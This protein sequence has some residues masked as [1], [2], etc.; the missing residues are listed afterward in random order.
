MA[1]ATTAAQV[2]TLLEAVDVS[3]SATL[4]LLDSDDQF[5]LDISEDLK[6]G[7]IRRSNYADIHGTCDLRIARQLQWGSARLQL[8]LTVTSDLVAL[9][10][11]WSMG[12]YLPGIP[13]RPVGRTPEVWSVKGSDKL[14]LLRSP[15]GRAVSA[16]EGDGYIATV[17][18]LIAEAGE[19]KVRI[20][21]ASVAKVLVTTRSWELAQETTFLRVIND[22]LAAIGYRGL[23][24]DRDGY[25]RSEVYQAPSERSA[26]WNYDADDVNTTIVAP[27]RLIGADYFDAPNVWIRIRNNPTVGAQTEDAGIATETNQSDGPTSIDARGGWI[28]RDIRAVD[29]ADQESLRA[30]AVAAADAGRRVANELSMPTGRNPEHWHFTV[31]E[32]VDA[33]IGATTK[34]VESEWV[35]PVPPNAGKMSHTLRA[36]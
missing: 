4:H 21:Q 26:E 1:E 14:V 15:I 13:Q 24:V 34:Y 16:L 7:T 36:V 29:A 3:F 28:K 2:R 5:R 25:F 6:G 23:W 35:M 11:T 30:Q 31:A 22:L 32:L 17:E 9:T 10:R 8:Y 19:T 12:V 18:A 33:A 20:D 27:E